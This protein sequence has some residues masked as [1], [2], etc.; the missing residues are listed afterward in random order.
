MS[1]AGSE[2]IMIS[3]LVVVRIVSVHEER[4]EG[5]TRNRDARFQPQFCHQC[6]RGHRHVQQ[7]WRFHLDPSSGR[8]LAL[9]CRSQSVWQP[10]AVAPVKSASSFWCFPRQCV[11]GQSRVWGPS[12]FCSTWH[13]SNK[14]SGPC[15]SPLLSD[16]HYNLRL[17]L[18]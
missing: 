8:D 7:L 17:S 9:S 11:R 1:A 14:Q 3:P 12:H 4:K 6:S 16:M 18:P 5:Q 13:F 15:S 2:C 10:G